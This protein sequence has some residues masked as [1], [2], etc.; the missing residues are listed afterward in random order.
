LEWL[1]KESA[2]FG[3]EV[4]VTGRGNIRKDVI[5]TVRHATRSASLPF[6]TLNEDGSKGMVMRQCTKEYKIE[7]IQKELRKILG[8]RPRQ[9]IKE[10]V[11]LWMGISTDEIHRVKPSR[12][13]WIDNKYPLIEKGMNRLDCLTWMVR[14]GYPEPPKSSCI[15]CPF[16]DDQM[17]L[18]M[19]RTDPESWMDAVEF[20]KTIRDIP[21][22]K[23]K[24]Y[25]HRS[26]VPLDQVDLNENQ[27]EIDWFTEECEGMC[28]V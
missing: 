16:H 27:L 6:F 4:V 15:G 13:N 25:L 9:R 8:Y 5:N 14:K 26:C 24:A 19:K 1:I 22:V 21:T 20:D 28:G 17:W 11:N 7:P 2:K 23:G 10:T 18:A 12:M 3:I